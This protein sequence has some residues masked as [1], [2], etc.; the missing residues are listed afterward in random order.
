MVD[1]GGGKSAQPCGRRHVG[2]EVVPQLEHQPW[3][4][5]WG[6]DAVI[7]PWIGVTRRCPAAQQDDL[8]SAGDPLVDD[9]FAAR[10]GMD[11]EARPAVQGDDS[12]TGHVVPLVAMGRKPIPAGLLALIAGFVRGEGLREAGAA[13]GV[14]EPGR[15]TG[16]RALGVQGG[17]RERATSARVRRGEY[18]AVGVGGELVTKVGREHVG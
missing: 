1:L 7:G 12:D 10:A 8:P 4:G 9:F 18:V 15:R 13:R 11:G 5:V 14:G 17:H 2:R 16:G 3:P 6:I